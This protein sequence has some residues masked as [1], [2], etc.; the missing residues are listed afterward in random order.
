M[1]AGHQLTESFDRYL[2][3]L[4]IQAKLR[5]MEQI[6]SARLHDHQVASASVVLD[7]L[8][9]DLRAAGALPPQRRPSP[10]RLFFGPLQPFLLDRPPERPRRGRIGRQSL[11]SIWAWICRDLVPSEAKT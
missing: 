2:K 4:P 8:R 11:A 5:L 10:S 1:Q 6:E 3:R 7:T 9:K